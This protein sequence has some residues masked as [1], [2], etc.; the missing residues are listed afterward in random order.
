MKHRKLRIL[1]TFILTYLKNSK[2]NDLQSNLLEL[3]ASGSVHYQSIYFTI[4]LF[5]GYSFIGVFDTIWWILEKLHTGGKR[6]FR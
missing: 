3:V 6:I 2:F 1:F 5:L 4:G